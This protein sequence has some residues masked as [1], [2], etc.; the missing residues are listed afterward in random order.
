MKM[1][2]ANKRTRGRIM[3]NT[4]VLEAERV[5]NGS[6]EPQDGSILE[7]EAH[8]D[9]AILWWQG[10][11]CIFYSDCEPRKAILIILF[12]RVVDKLILSLSRIEITC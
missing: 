2:K 8:A 10:E 4:V 11:K 7:E 3:I 9:Y 5:K 1:R 12:I 6:Y